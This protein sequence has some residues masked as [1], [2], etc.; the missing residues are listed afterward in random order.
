MKESMKITLR[1]RT[2]TGDSWDIF[3][4]DVYIVSCV[5]TR[6]E[7]VDIA[8]EGAK[9]ALAFV[10]LTGLPLS[11]LA[12]WTQAANGISNAP[13]SDTYANRQIGFALVP[14]SKLVN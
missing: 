5:G 9:L 12:S 10:N 8:N 13:K 4:D 2:E 6:D 14:G 3:Y 11:A 7:A 1:A